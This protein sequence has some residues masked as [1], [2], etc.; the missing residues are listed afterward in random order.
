MKANIY[1]ATVLLA[2]G[3]TACNEEMGPLADGPV[4][5][6]VT[7]DISQVATRATATA[8]ENED[9]I[10]IFP[11]KNDALDAEQANRL[12]T[13]NGST[14]T[15]TKPYY[16]QDREEVTFNAYYPYDA[17]LTA[18]AHTIDINTRA[19]YQKIETIEGT[20]IEWRTNDYLFASAMTNVSE[21][22]V[23]YT[24]DNAFNHVMTQVV[25]V[26]NAGTDDGV[27]DLSAL[28][29]YKIATPLVMDGSFDAA[30]GEVTLDADA[31]AEVIAMTVTGPA[32]TELRADPLILLPQAISGS[33]LELEVAYNGQT[34]KAELNAPTAG[35]Q[36]G[37]SYTY[38][39]T[40][41]NTKLEVSNAAISDWST[42]RDFNGN[43]NAT[44]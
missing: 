28:S 21:P 20:A 29:G 14:F 13:Y 22:S 1:T 18:T 7:A 44:L 31:K 42:D 24:G 5:L 10:G 26:F 19:E 17:D 9:P 34:Y 38:T 41:S 23:S 15:D 12:Y 2:L 6:S 32:A 16:F 30:T 40:V 3:L 4:A 37:Y 27:S 39:V 43:G 11:K 36:A 25:F 35:L 8:F 33:E